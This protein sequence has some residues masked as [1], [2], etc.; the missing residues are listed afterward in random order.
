MLEMPEYRHLD[1]LF[2]TIY[3]GGNA[4]IQIHVMRTMRRTATSLAYVPRFVFCPSVFEVSGTHHFGLERLIWMRVGN[5]TEMGDE[6]RGRCNG[7][8]A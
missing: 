1:I 2:T 4:N 6:N 5:F 8:D 3:T 7:S